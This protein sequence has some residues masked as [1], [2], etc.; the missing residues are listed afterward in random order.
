MRLACRVYPNL[1][2]IY[3]ASMQGLGL[4][5]SNEF[6]TTNGLSG[7]ECVNKLKEMATD[8]NIVPSN[9]SFRK[10]ICISCEELQMRKMR[11]IEH[12]CTLDVMRK[13]V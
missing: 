4:S 11:K 9:P 2:E 6:K 5:K 12:V 7:A 8:F 3:L 13:F 10:N 1:R